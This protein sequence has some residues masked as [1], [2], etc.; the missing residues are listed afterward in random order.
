MVSIRWVQTAAVAPAAALLLMLLP[1]TAGAAPPP[2]Q[3]FTADFAK[4]ELCGFPVHFL[5]NDRTKLHTGPGAVYSTGPLTATIT[6]QD[7]GKTQTFNIS[8]PTF[9]NGTLTGHA[10]VLQPASR[11]IGPAFLIL[12]KGR[13]TFTENNT[14]A[15]ITGSTTDVCAV[16]A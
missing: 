11:N 13:V 10:L 3:T 5:V 12:N 16:L 2:G 7:T 6:N 9:K 15:T 1:T 4:G 8:G 14:I